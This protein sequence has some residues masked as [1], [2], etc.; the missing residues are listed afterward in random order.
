MPSPSSEVQPF[1]SRAMLWAIAWPMAAELLLGIAVGLVGVALAARVSDA[2]AAAYGIGNTLFATFFIVFRIIGAGVSVVITQR[3][4]AGDRAGADALARAGLGA[5]LWLGVA[6]ALVL[7]AGAGPLLQALGTPAEVQPLAA[8]YLRVLALAL[9]LD[10]LNALMGAVLRAHLHVRRALLISLATHALHLLACLPLMRGDGPLPA[11]GLG[12]FALAMVISRVAAVALHR[13]GWREHLALVPRA[14]DWWRL[15]RGVLA[16]ALHIGVPGAAENIAYRLAAL[17][18]TSVVAHL[19][20]A[21]LAAHAYAQQLGGLLILGSLSLGLA[22]EILVGH[23]VGA[24]RID[25]ARRRVRTS[26]RWGLL[27]STLSALLLALLGPPAIGLFTQDEALVELAVTLLWIGVA[28]E[29]GRAMNLVYVNA[30][31]A[32]GD[33][34]WPVAVAA[35]SMSIVMAGG[36]WLLGSVMGLGLAGVWIALVADEWLRGLAMAWR[37]HGGAWQERARRVVA[38]AAV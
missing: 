14:A 5:S 31:R 35:L 6:V 25:L 3:L 4:G 19:G 30:L 2:A 33:V 10:A 1:Q 23:D 28:L 36:A 16:P 8:P 34:R 9:G 37:W 22:A 27:V 17:V 20:T 13:R 21:S 26:I 15:E 7:A 24:G 12:G 18:V 11:L 29:P 32:A 38:P